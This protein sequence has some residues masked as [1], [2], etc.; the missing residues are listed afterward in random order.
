MYVEYAQY[1]GNNYWDVTNN[2]ADPIYFQAEDGEA[3]TIEVG[4]TQ[5]IFHSPSNNRFTIQGATQ[6]IQHAS[7][8]PNIIVDETGNIQELR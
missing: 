6:N 8:A 7:D 2:S 3:Q 4:D 5:R 1:Q